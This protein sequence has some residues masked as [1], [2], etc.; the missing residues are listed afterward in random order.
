VQQKTPR[1]LDLYFAGEVPADAVDDYLMDWTNSDS[2]VQL[3]VYLGMTWQEY[4]AWGRHGKLPA[5]AEHEALPQTDYVFV[6]PLRDLTPLRVHGPTRCR[7]TCPVHWPSDHPQ[8]DW[9]LGWREDLGIMTRLCTHEQHHPDPDDQQVRLHPELADHDCDGCC[10]ATIDGD[11]FEEDEPVTE[12]L[13]AYAQA[14]TAGQ[15]GR[16]ERP[17]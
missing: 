7:P 4:Q 12:V 13:A 9:P 15:T 6:G 2:H 1:F 8:A 17:Q 16:T 14:Q 3:H 11:F 5:Q 10:R